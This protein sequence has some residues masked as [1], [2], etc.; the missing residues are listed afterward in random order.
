M[1]RGHNRERAL[2]NRLRDEDWFAMRAPASLGVADVVAL[3]AGSTPMLIESKSTIGPYDHF[4]PTARQRLSDAAKLAGAAAW[5][6]WWPKNGKLRFI[7]EREW[8]QPRR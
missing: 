1:S 8:P 2:V 6:A 4:G 5:L 7:A 3:R